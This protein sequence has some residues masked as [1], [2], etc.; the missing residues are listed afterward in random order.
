MKD[1]LIQFWKSSITALVSQD[2]PALEH[3]CAGRILN[4]LNFIVVIVCLG[5]WIT[6]F[7]LL[8][9]HLFTE[10]LSGNILT[11]LTC[12]T[13]FGG[14]VIAVFVGALAGNSLRRTF[15]KMLIR[16]KKE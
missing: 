9:D 15:W 11:N 13:F 5:L 1:R 10:T 4:A 16:R 7:L 12:L 2:D 3:S 6:A 8:K 14:L